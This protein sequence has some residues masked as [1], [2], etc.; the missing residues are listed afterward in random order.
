MA[1]LGF[2]QAGL[3]SSSTPRAIFPHLTAIGEYLGNSERA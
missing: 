2:V 1:G 3:K